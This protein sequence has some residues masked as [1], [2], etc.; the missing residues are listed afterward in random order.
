MK[1]SALEL[2]A[3]IAL[4]LDTSAA[5]G[6]LSRLVWIVRLFSS[7]SPV[8]DALVKRLQMMLCV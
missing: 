1:S 2:A 8:D 7:G 5:Q 4:E 6:D 3:E